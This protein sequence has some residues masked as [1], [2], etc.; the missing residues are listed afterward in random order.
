MPRDDFTAATLRFYGDATVLHEHRRWDGVVYLC[1][2]IQECGLKSQL[3]R[4]IRKLSP[5]SAFQGK[6]FGHPPD[7]MTADE[8]ALAA[9]TFEHRFGSSGGEALA[10]LR[11]EWLSIAA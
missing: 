2:Y 1:G 7:D 8:L 9:C 6:H 3:A 4:R 11:K 5:I 10:A